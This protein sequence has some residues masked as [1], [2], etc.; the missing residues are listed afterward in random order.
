MIYVETTQGMGQKEMKE[1][2]VGSAFKH[3]ICD[4]L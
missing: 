1:N 3:N 4:M 2:S